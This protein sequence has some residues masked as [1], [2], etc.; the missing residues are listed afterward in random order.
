MVIII[1]RIYDYIANEIFFLFVNV[2][3]I[4]SDKKFV[5]KFLRNFSPYFYTT[6]FSLLYAYLIN[7]VI[8]YCIVKKNDYDCKESLIKKIKR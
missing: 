1:V 4:F 7:S 5:K 2:R 8:I 3:I 6:L